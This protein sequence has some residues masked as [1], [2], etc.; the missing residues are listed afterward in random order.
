MNKKISAFKLK[1]IKI[2][3]ASLFVVITSLM[4]INCQ[5]RTYKNMDKENT[6]V[7]IRQQYLISVPNNYKISSG[8]G[9][10]TEFV[11]IFTEDGKITIGY[12]SGVD[13]KYAIKTNH[14]DYLKDSYDK[15]ERIK[16][17]NGKVIWI[18]FSSTKNKIRDVKGEVFVEFDDEL[19]EIL[20]FSCNSG[21]LNQV[22]Q[23]I[24]T[25]KKK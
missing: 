1:Q 24:N 13:D 18:A 19:T 15:T 8:T 17:L 20:S 9:D 21:N 11:Q 7:E 16:R 10:D 2:I 23:L 14:V 4:I 25:L 6:A 3:F 12:E 5:T 22:R